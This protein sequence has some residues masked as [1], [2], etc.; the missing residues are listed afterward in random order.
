MNNNTTTVPSSTTPANL[1]MI[2]FSTLCNGVNV[3]L[4]LTVGTT[5]IT[6]WGY[7]TVVANGYHTCN[8]SPSEPSEV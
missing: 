1:V 3:P 7:R 5:Y 6:Q 2:P 8:I 4:F